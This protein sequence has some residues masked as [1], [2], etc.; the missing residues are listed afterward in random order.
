MRLGRPLQ[1]RLRSHH[2]SDTN[3]AIQKQFRTFLKRQALKSLQTPSGEWALACVVDLPAAALLA[4]TSRAAWENKACT[5]SFPV[6]ST[7]RPNMMSTLSLQH[8]E[9]IYR[10][11]II[12][13][14][15]YICLCMCIYTYMYTAILVST[16]IMYFRGLGKRIPGF[17]TW[18]L[19]IW[20]PCIP[21]VGVACTLREEACGTC[22]APHECLQGPQLP[23]C[24]Q[25][26]RPTC[27]LHLSI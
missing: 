16:H 23:R 3:M 4:S 6:Y 10:C 14:Y 12:H 18:I 21:R 5:H 22:I 24:A 7:L 19:T 27:S 2:D 1:G 8:I 13:I 17:V 26:A 20:I 15:S 11:I 25:H 9:A